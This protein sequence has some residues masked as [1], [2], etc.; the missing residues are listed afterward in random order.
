M[1]LVKRINSINE[2]LYGLIYY[3]LDSDYGSIEKLPRLPT[4]STFM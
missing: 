4:T 1:I 3:T 2:T